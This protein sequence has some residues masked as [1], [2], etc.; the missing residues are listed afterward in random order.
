MNLC[1]AELSPWGRH[2]DLLLHPKL[3]AALAQQLPAGSCA[4]CHTLVSHTRLALATGCSSKAHS[5]QHAQA[6]TFLL[7]LMHYAWLHPSLLQ[8]HHLPVRTWLGRGSRCNSPKPP[9]L[10]FW[11]K[12]TPSRGELLSCSPKGWITIYLCSNPA[13]PAGWAGK[14]QCF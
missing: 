5:H 9:V 6:G 2:R 1:P 14:K 8:M 4:L 11:M 13:V 3:E 7:T 12:Q 10:T